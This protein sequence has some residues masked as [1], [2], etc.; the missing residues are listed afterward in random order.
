MKLNIIASEAI[1]V[2]AD[3]ERAMQMKF[4]RLEK[5]YK[6]ITGFEVIMTRLDAFP[7]N[8]CLVEGRVLIPKSSFFCRERAKTFE[9]A[10]DQVIDNLTRQL[11][12]QKEQRTETW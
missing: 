8:N 5:I 12:W 11:K 7:N 4:S 3:L 9:K 1:Q 6:H 10:I 2:N